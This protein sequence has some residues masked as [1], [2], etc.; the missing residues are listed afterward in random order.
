LLKKLDVTGA[1]RERSSGVSGRT[2][3]DSL[4]V[5]INV[6]DFYEAKIGQTRSAN[7]ALRTVAHEIDR[8]GLQ[9]VEEGR[10]L[11]IRLWVELFPFYR[12]F[13]N[14]MRAAQWV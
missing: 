3:S 1:T 2:V 8:D 12:S 4:I 10:D 6:V 5:L 7:Q 9:G 11:E 13:I 14:L